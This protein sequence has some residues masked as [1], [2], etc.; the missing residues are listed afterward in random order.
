MMRRR[1]HRWRSTSP[2]AMRS[3]PAL[4]R[5]RGEA[6]YT[7]DFN[8]FRSCNS[9]LRYFRFGRLDHVVV[10]LPALVLQCDALDHHR[11]GVGVQVGQ[12]LIL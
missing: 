8:R 4:R 9:W 5:G 7:S 2:A 3:P 11:G 12:G 10:P 1:V 6:N